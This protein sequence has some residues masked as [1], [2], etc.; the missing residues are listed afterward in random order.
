MHEL[1]GHQQE[2][3]KSE[4]SDDDPSNE[5]HI[6]ASVPIIQDNRG[7]IYFI[8]KSEGIC[9]IHEINPKIDETNFAIFEFKS[10]YVFGFCVTNN[11]VFYYMD[12]DKIIYKLKRSKDQRIL[13]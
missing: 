11:D 1:K 8:T 6:Y 2:D 9:T 13:C 7:V 3:E 12:D 5:E 10:N 4:T